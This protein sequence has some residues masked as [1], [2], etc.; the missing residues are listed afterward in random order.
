MLPI[1]IL[2]PTRNCAALVPEHLQSLRDWMDLAEEVVVVDS[3]SRDGTVELLRSGLAHPRVRFLNHPPGLYQSWNFGIQNAGAKYI[4]IATVGDG[5]SRGGIGHLF[6]VAER[7][8]SDV[9]I[10]KPDFVSAGGQ[11]LPGQRWPVDV[12]LRRLRID[13][14]RLLSTAEQFLFMATNLWGSILGSS[15]SNLY[16]A[17]CLKQRPFPTEYGTTGDS[18][19]SILNI[20]E[21]KIAITPERFSTFRFHE[22]SYAPEDYHIE[23]LLLKLFRLVQCVVARQRTGNFAARRILDEVRWTELESALELV[24][25]WQAKLEHYRKERLP[26]FLNPRAWQARAA[27]N[28][29]ERRIS[30]ITDDVVAASRRSASTLEAPRT[31]AAPAGRGPGAG[32][33]R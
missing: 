2:I 18:G 16:R 1:S 15:A 33:H 30:D 19:W 7:F 26:W 28:Q 5:I 13:R 24:P 25:F 21:V 4:Y 29:A 3:D 10:S 32:P 17:D 31:G 12:I 23:A 9:V 27:R 14:P 20:F 22:K 11:A 6:D 8:Q